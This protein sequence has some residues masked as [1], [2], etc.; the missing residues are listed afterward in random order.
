MTWLPRSA[1]GETAFARVFG[2]S[3]ELYARYREFDDLFWTTRPVDPVLL[4]LCRLRVAQILGCA[5]R[6]R[7]RSGIGEAR[8]AALESWRGRPDA[9]SAVERA[10]L[11]FAEKFVLDP[12][13]V[14]DD[15]AAAVKA[16]LA[17]AGLVAFVEALASFDGFLR[18][19]AILGAD[20]GE[21]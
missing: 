7:P 9:F 15:D 3:P 14:G 20:D 8:V 19:G 13:G 21:A 2:L 6:P 10:C 12:H 1:Q 16:H 5:A 18:F 17:D 4:E 11:G